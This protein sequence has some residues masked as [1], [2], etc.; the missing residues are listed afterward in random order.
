MDLEYTLVDTWRTRSHFSSSKKFVFLKCF[1]N[2]IFEIVS[3]NKVHYSKLHQIGMIVDQLDFRTWCNVAFALRD[4]V[5]FGGSKLTSLSLD[6]NLE[7]DNYLV[8]EICQHFKDSMVDLSL[9]KCERLDLSFLP[10]LAGFKALQ[11]LSLA[12][13]AC[14]DDSAIKYVALNCPQLNHLDISE[15]VLLTDIAL[16]S[17]TRLSSIFR[18]I[19]AANLPKLTFA[20]VNEFLFECEEL[21][22]IN[23]SGCVGLTF[24]GI[25]ISAHSLLQVN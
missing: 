4:F 22:E 15:C 8:F 6:G 17:L 3:G 7:V 1:S 13:I 20:G 9:A 11:R 18:H 2:N 25:V 5:K 24:I 16:R 21:E 23:F 14:I 10:A 19:I 12:G